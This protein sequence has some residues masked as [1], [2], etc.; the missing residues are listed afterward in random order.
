M[1]VSGD[2]SDISAIYLGMGAVL[3]KL[4]RFDEAREAYENGL[5]MNER[6]YGADNSYRMYFVN[7]LGKVAEGS[8]DLEAAASWYEDAKR[9]A[10]RDMPGSANLAFALSSVGRVSMLRGDFDSALQPLRTARQIFEEKLPDHWVLGDVKWRLGLCLVESGQSADAEPLILA[11][12]EIVE[13]QWGPDHASTADA[14]AAVARL[15][16]TW[17]KPVKVERT[18]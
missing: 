7:G 15:Y 16:E 8:G 11:G 9:L 3:V 5:A 6:L 17:G 18:P 13:N 4:S 12:A 2:S 10:M 1:Y 14:R